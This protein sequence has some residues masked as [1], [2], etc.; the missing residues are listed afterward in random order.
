MKNSYKVLSATAVA[1][2]FA[3]SLSAQQLPL[4]NDVA[5]GQGDAEIDGQAVV[6]AAFGL[7]G[8]II[9]VSVIAGL[10]ILTVVDQDGTTSTTVAP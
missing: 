6:G 2:I 4:N 3:T 8:T 10:T 5:G 7:T 9:G 1:A